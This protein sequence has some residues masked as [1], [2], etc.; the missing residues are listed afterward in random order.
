MS[1]GSRPAGGYREMLVSE[2]AEA[3]SP[4][5]P[6][7]GDWQDT[8]DLLYAEEPEHMARL[9]DSLR[10]RGWREPISL[11]AFGP[12]EADTQRSVE[13]GTHR[14]VI[15]LRE[16]VISV[17]VVTAGELPPYEETPWAELEVKLTSGELT[18]D[19]DWQIFD[20]LRSFPL[21]DELWLNSDAAGSQSGV[22]SFSYY[23]L[24]E[25]R[26]ALLK[27]G[28][29]ALLEATFPGRRFSLSVKLEHPEE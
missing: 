21:S 15:A 28:A 8:A 3:Y 9:S 24:E 4:V 13:D 7:D 25:H 1:T 27:R 22:W 19:E 29:R 12:L 16:G 17:P 10:E 6:P 23:D 20:V 5:Y 2:I 11:S 14:M 26:F 18:E